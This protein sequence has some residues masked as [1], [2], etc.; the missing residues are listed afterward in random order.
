MKNIYE[1]LDLYKFNSNIKMNNLRKNREKYNKLIDQYQ[2]FKK[3]FSEA[4]PNKEI[5]QKIAKFIGPSKALELNAER[6]LWTYLLSKEGKKIKANEPDLDIYFTH[7]EFEKNNIKIPNMF[8]SVSNYLDQN[9]IIKYKPN[10]LL[11]V[12][13]DKKAFHYLKVFGGSKLVYIGEPFTKVSFQ[14]QSSASSEFLQLLELD[15]EL[16]SKEKI[17]SP[18]GI[19]DYVFF[20]QRKNKLIIPTPNKITKLLFDYGP[21][22]NSLYKSKQQQFYQYFIYWDLLFPVVLTK[23]ILDKFKRIINNQKT[24]IYNDTRGLIAFLLNINQRKYIN[25]VPKNYFEKYETYL[26]QF[27][28]PKN[29]TEITEFRPDT[30][31]N[32]PILIIN[33]ITKPEQDIN[34]YLINFNSLFKNRYERVIYIGQKRDYYLGRTVKK[35]L[36]ERLYLSETIY[37]PYFEDLESSFETEILI[38]QK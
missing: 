26:N 24:I 17:D 27:I 18:F 4:K 37:P 23:I 2:E 31:K 9:A 11:M 13:P 22:N 32:Y 15:W 30:V 33:N 36:G 8:Y 35:I 38:Y 20:Y 1:I 25:L 14:V 21:N 19:N 34:I 29:Y 12:W 16:K 5:I 28:I 10:V 7:I 3:Y 6:G